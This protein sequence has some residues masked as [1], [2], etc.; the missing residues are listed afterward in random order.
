M[1]EDRYIVYEYN[2]KA[3]PNYRG[4]RFM[5]SFDPLFYD[6]EH[7]DNLIIIA[8][9]LNLEDAQALIKVKDRKN[10]NAFLSS[11][12]D[13]LRTPSTDAFI[14]RLMHGD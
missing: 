6:G 7:N 9:D 8:K 13:A 14:L 5:T 4:C 11:I 12:P 3:S 10:S 2:E 1:S